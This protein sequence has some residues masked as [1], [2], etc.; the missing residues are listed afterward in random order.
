VVGHIRVEPL[1]DK[2]QPLRLLET[3]P[4]GIRGVE[5]AQVVAGDAQTVQRVVDLNK[6]GVFVEM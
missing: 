5:K 4:D 2:Q 3:E 1:G 6:R